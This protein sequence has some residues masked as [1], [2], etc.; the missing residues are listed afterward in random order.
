LV[1]GSAP[2]CN[3]QVPYFADQP[4]LNTNHP[5]NAPKAQPARAQNISLQQQPGKDFTEQ[6]LDFK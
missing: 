4:K 1:T 2:L 3:R 5:P 6:P